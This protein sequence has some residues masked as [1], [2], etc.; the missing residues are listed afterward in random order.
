MKCRQL[1]LVVLVL[2]LPA[3]TKGGGQ[4]LDPAPPEMKALEKLVGTWKVENIGIVPE[5]TRSTST[6]KRE[7]VLGGRFIEDRQFDDQGKHTGSGMFTYDVGRK[8]YRSWYFD[9]SGF[10][11]EATGTWDE[12]KQ[13]FTFT[14]KQG[15]GATGVTTLRFRDEN[16]FDWSVIVTDA[17]GDISYHLEGKSVRQK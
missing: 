1:T 16:S 11:V 3:S 9:Q 12:T 15:R 6:N 5:K 8:A 13:T 4:E 14:N 10:Y 17:R 7:L 2:I